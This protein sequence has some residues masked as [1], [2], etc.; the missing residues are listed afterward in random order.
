MN[1]STKFALSLLKASKIQLLKKHLMKCQN[2]EEQ[3]I[4]KTFIMLLLNGSKLKSL[5]KKS[6]CLLIK[7]LLS[8]DR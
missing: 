7:D 1:L 8:E 6:E 3:F 2:I 4:E 5:S